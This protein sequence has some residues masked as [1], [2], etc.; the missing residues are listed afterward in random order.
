[1]LADGIDQLTLG[2]RTPERLVRV[3]TVNLD[4]VLGKTAQALQ[5][6]ADAVDECA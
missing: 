4:E 6:H 1:M 3:L 2:G 5:R